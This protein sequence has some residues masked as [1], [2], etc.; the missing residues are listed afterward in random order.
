M[1]RS[2]AP[3]HGGSAARAVE[4]H[5]PALRRDVTLASRRGRRL[6]PAA[7]AF[8]QLARSADGT[9]APRA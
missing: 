2:G 4:L 1:P 8:L 9:G 5:G 3:R 6:T 7:R